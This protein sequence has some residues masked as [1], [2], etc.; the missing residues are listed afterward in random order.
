MD[1]GGGAAG[2]VPG[3]DRGTARAGGRAGGSELEAARTRLAG[4]EAEVTALHL[5]RRLLLDYLRD[6]AGGDF[7]PGWCGRRARDLLGRL[8]GEGGRRD[9]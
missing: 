5:D 3:A 9:G 1:P 2:G 8:E 7:G 4:L 6:V